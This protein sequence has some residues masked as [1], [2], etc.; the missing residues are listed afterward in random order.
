MMDWAEQQASV[1]ISDVALQ[2]KFGDKL[3]LLTRVEE[4]LYSNLSSFT[5]GEAFNLASNT[6]TGK[7]LEAFR[8]LCH[9][10]DPQTAGRRTNIVSSLMSPPQDKL[11]ELGSAL[12]SWEENVRQ[13]EARRGPHGERKDID[14]D[15]KIGGLMNMV[16]NNLREHL[17]FNQPS[18]GG[19]YQNVRLAVSMYL[20]GRQGLKMKTTTSNIT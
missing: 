11:D 16:P 8:K 10:F 3:G 5:E 18:N 20:E 14:D 4:A 2:T 19:V 9:R 17:T 7:G 6:T 12:E 15:M 1:P 13:F